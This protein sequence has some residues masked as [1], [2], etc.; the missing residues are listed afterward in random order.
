MPPV[1]LAGGIEKAKLFLARLWV[2]E[3]NCQLWLDA[4]SQYQRVW[5]DA[6]GVFKNEPQHDWTSHAADVLRY[7]AI[8]ESN[9]V[10][11]AAYRQPPMPDRG[12]YYGGW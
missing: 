6:R 11:R 5:D 7:A 10:K 12:E 2:D 9:M 1:A 8:S 4:I 3:K